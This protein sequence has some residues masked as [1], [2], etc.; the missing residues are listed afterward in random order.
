MTIHVLSHPIAKAQLSKL[1]E[2]TTS[3]KDFREGVHQI[4]LFLGI[5]ATRSLEEESFEG[6]SPVGK[7]KGTAIKPHIGRRMAPVVILSLLPD[8]PVYH[9]GLFR[10]KVSL[11]PVEYYSKL[12]PNPTVEIVYLLDPLI[13][14]GGTARA[15]LAMLLD[16][17]IK[18]T[19]IK[20]LCVLASQQGLKEIKDEYP[21]V[22]VGAQNEIFLDF[23]N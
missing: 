20:L 14:T 9:I 15:A 3:P 13:A 6:Q 18:A 23:P 21:D 5:E 11:Q 16:W 17:G 22:E 10:E 2:A 7:F 4:S 12:P 1:R 19:N 8:A